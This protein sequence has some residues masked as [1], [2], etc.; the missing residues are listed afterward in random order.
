M[1]NW[2]HRFCTELGNDF[3]CEVD[4]DFIKDFSNLIGLEE[5]ILH[6]EQALDIILDERDTGSETTSTKISNGS[7]RI[8]GDKT[9]GETA[10]KL[11]SLIHARF[12]LTDRGCK[13]MLYKYLQGD[14]GH[15]P[16]VLCS[17]SNVLPIGMSDRP[18]DETVKV[19]C[20][21]CNEVYFPR[22]LKHSY[23]DG[24]AFGRSF[25]HMFFMIFP[26][27][28][29]VKSAEKY[30]PRLHGFK[31]HPSA[32]TLPLQAKRNKVSAYSVRF[33]GGSL[34]K[35]SESLL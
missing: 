34:K 17:N 4:K 8:T 24:A 25:P 26:E 15:C 35:V 20:P 30:T 16:R 28:R 12:I 14:F 19:F 27:Y 31:I 2:I 13:K 29:P 6:F 3:F 32:Y 1:D 10:E 11:Y 9:P 7:C 21:R 18:G 33:N 5:M 22:L 23:I